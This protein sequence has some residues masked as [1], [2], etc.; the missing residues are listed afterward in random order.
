L[1][2]RYN[3]QDRE[4]IHAVFVGGPSMPARV[5]VLV[6]FLAEALRGPAGSSAPGALG[7]NERGATLSDNAPSD[8]PVPRAGPAISLS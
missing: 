6:D 2:E 8:Q 1:L 5:R 3:P 4:A 7:P